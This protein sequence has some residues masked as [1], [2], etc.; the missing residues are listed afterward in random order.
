M[1]GI[2][3]AVSTT[4]ES[5]FH[6]ALSTLSHRGPDASGFWTDCQEM[7]MGHRRLSILDLSPEAGQPMVSVDGNQILVFNGEI[8]NFIEI[9]KELIKKGYL[10][11]NQSDSEVILYAYEEWGPSFLNRLNGMWAIAIWNQKEKELFLSRDRFGKKPL[12]YA[13]IGEQFIFASE[14]KAIYPFLPQVAPSA[15]FKWMAEN[16]FIYETTD[17]CL[18]DGIKRFPA[19][20]FGI[21]RNRALKLSRFWNTLDNLP[22]IPRSYNDQVEQF[23]ELFIDA[24]R[25]RMRS[26]VPV[27]TALSGGIDSSATISTMAHISRMNTGNRISKDWQHAFVATF[28]GTFIDE[29]KYARKVVEHIGI[30]ATF[31]V[32]DPLQHLDKL[33]Y[34]LYQFEELYLTCPIPM[35]ETYA[36]IKRQGV[37]VTL[38]GHGADELFAGYHTSV[39]EALKDAGLNLH[40]VHGIIQAFLGQYPQNS[41]QF[42][43]QKSA[44]YF[45]CYHLAQY[46]R[47]KIKPKPVNTD[48]EDLNG[49]D[50]FT[51]H[52]FIMT[53]E[54]ILPTLLRNYDRYS[55]MSGVEIR[56]PFMDHRLVAYAMALPWSSKVRNGYTKSIVRDAMRPFMPE[57]IVRRKTKIGFGSPIADWMQ[58]GMRQYLLDHISSQSFKQCGLI[59]PQTVKNNIEQAISMN[60]PDYYKA[61]QAWFSMTPYLWEQSLKQ[62]IQ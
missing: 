22:P 13:Q 53:H 59:D 11:R 16:S 34:Y 24:C 51:R 31:L 49:L 35:I 62:R 33:E 54:T 41:A 27:G 55:M 39:F 23:R 48:R 14:M 18:V 45:F 42:K 47:N 1:C 25:I 20:Y 38:D 32:I 19:G 7:M 3:G 44:F 29:S 36:A 9:K 43:K 46:L 60:P 40:A 6:R 61:E 10:F 21:Y 2:L 17:K 56:M 28:P 52:L 5:R 30:D 50:H 4:D 12:F 57:E 58:G 26:D 15:D 8:Y 37:S